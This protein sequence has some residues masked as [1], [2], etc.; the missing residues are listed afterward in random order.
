MAAPMRPVPLA[1]LLRVFAWTG[2]TSL[3][4]GRSAYFHDEMV[5]R[6]PWVTNQ[7]FVQDLTLSQML[8]GPNF[9]NLGVA[10]GYRLARGRGAAAAGLALVVPGG[11]VLL[12]LTILYFKTGLTPDARPALRGMGAAVVGLVMM[13]SARVAVG[14]L[15]GQRALL[16]ALV[17]FLGV[18]PLRIHTALVILLAGALSFALQRTREGA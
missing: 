6:R 5:V 1:R 9:S 12:A 4:G 15:R 13:T 2:F 14:A 18:G 10:I 16:V 8:P 3:G 11:L 17:T 7:E